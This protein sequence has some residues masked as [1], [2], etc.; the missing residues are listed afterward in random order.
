M[1]KLLQ[2]IGE[3]AIYALALILLFVQTDLVA[4]TD[5]TD[6]QTICIGSIEF[7]QVDY[8]ENGGE[9]TPGSTYAWAVTSGPFAGTLTPNQGP[10]GSSN[11]I[12][13]DWGASPDGAYVLEVVETANGCPGAPI[14]LNIIL[15]PEIIP[16]FDAIGPLCQ[17]STPPTLPTSSTNS[18][19]ITGTWDAAIS[20]VSPGTTVYTFTP[21]PDQCATTATL[22]IEVTP[23]VTPTFDAIGPLC[24]NSTAPALPATSIEGITGTWSPA[25]VS[26]TT[27]GITTYTFTPDDPAQCAIPT[28]LDID[29]TPEVTPLFDAIGPLCEN[30]TAPTLP[31]TSTNGITGTWDA[32]I[33][34]TTTGI[35][36]YTFT[37]DNPAQ[38]AIPT[39]LD[40]D[41]TPE[42]T[43]L[44]DA[45]GPLCENSTAPVLPT[46]STNGITG[47]WDAAIST[48]T[49][50]ITTYTFTPDDPA[51]CAIP[52]TLDIDVTPEVTP[53]FDAIGPL[54][55]NSTAPT[56]PTT[57]TNGI[58]GTWDAAISTT[59]TGITTYTFTPDDPAQCA[60][61]TTLDI[62]V[63]PEVTPLFDAIGPLCENSTAPVL[64][65]T[66]TNGIT[67]TWDAAIST[68]TTGVTTYTFTPDNPAQCAIP[69][70]LDI[71]VTPE[72]T[73]LFDAIGPLCENSTAPVLPTT[74]TNG[75]TGTWDAAISTT[76]TGITTYT[77]TPDDPA[78][79][80]IP[81]TL[82]ILINPLPLIAV[83]SETICDGETTTLTATG[84][85]TYVWSPATGLSATTGDVVDAS[86]ST[87]T[88]YTVTGTDS[89]TCEN[90][91]TSTVTVNPLPNTS[92]IFHD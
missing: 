26:T 39:T 59:T 91:A 65:T 84:A 69:T 48:T 73:P 70:T 6:P 75:I 92:A 41:V 79:C 4:Q 19:A 89:N 2:I 14:I 12:Q 57:S 64:P 29:V 71:D 47:T 77:F 24:E 35:T 33:S 42:V 54:C 25:T 72:V 11:R 67:G 38:C 20:T 68:T 43:P 45:I 34:T 3:K 63:T 8:L 10:S 56:L 13:I 16:T 5:D 44:F 61:P 86:P 23:E 17:N 90:S 27:T 31:T 85:D 46:T 40:I 62:D 60:I 87:T 15:T 36:T 7:Y 21:D 51:Q 32:A 22:S 1:N 52:T 28:T 37:P 74:S 66:S 55:E 81:T 58:T 18:P 76:T 49:T 80:A 82:D 53:L 88:V 83:N 78:Q 50:G 30:S 9:G